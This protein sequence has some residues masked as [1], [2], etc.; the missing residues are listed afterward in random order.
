MNKVKKYGRKKTVTEAMM[1]GTLDKMTPNQ[2]FTLTG[3]IEPPLKVSP[4]WAITMADGSIYTTMNEHTARIIA[5]QEEI[6]HMLARLLH[7]QG[8][9]RKQ[10]KKT[11]GKTPKRKKPAGKRK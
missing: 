6:K 5:S 2:V 11:K 10:E 8:K 1:D 4:E 9:K 3:N 7:S